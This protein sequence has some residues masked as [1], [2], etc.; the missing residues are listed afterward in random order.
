MS[1]LLIE[2]FTTYTKYDDKTKRYYIDNF[3]TVFKFL[4]KTEYIKDNYFQFINQLTNKHNYINIK[5]KQYFEKG[6][7]KSE[8]EY[9]YSHSVC[10]VVDKVIDIFNYFNQDRIIFN[11]QYKIKFNYYILYLLDKKFKTDEKHETNNYMKF[12]NNNI[13]LDNYDMNYR[14]TL[15]IQNREIKNIYEY[16]DRKIE[17]TINGNLEY[18]FNSNPDL[19]KS[20]IYNL[21]ENSKNILIDSIIKYNENEILERT[22]KK[23]NNNKIVKSMCLNM[24]TKCHDKINECLNDELKDFIKS[25]RSKEIMKNE[26]SAYIGY[27]PAE[28]M[29]KKI[30]DYAKRMDINKD[31]TKRVDEISNK[32]K[33]LQLNYII[34]TNQNEDKEIKNENEEDKN[35]NNEIK[36]A[37]KQKRI[38]NI[39]E[40]FERYGKSQYNLKLSKLKSLTKYNKLQ[41]FKDYLIKKNVIKSDFKIAGSTY[42]LSEEQKTQFINDFINLFY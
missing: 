31:L 38:N 37:L 30:Y 35:E 32:I 6:Y 1:D 33:T 15:L 29:G 27:I 2:Y 7:T 34:N 22:A 28:T 25:D 36:E 9:I 13:Y 19:I 41:E 3:E 42:R 20:L 4:E 23:I 24:L 8:S 10:D 16:I 17:D 14:I 18:L 11:E 21:N 26:F 5:D 39:N 12:K 40:C